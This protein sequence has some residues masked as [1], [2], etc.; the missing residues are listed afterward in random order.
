M[1]EHSPVEIVRT[2]LSM[3]WGILLVVFGILAIGL[4]FIA[5]VALNVAWLAHHFGWRSPRD[6]CIA[7]PSCG[8]IHLE[9]ASRTR[10]SH[11]RSVPAHAS[12]AGCGHT[13]FSP[14]IA[15]PD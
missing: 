5:A 12:G 3:M 10:I 14:G 1:A 9:V 6:A 11:L 4:P 15:L 2:T 7:R 13:N 8:Q